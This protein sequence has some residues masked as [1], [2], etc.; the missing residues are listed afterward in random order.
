MNV[1]NRLIFIRLGVAFLRSAMGTKIYLT[2][3]NNQEDQFFI[4]SHDEWY[5]SFAIMMA[6]P[7]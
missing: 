7:Y 6:H 3:A 4:K 2:G 1:Q 5:Y